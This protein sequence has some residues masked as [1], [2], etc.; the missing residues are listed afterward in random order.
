MS[1]KKVLI[2]GDSH[3]AFLSGENEKSVLLEDG[4]W[5]GSHQK[6]NFY[7]IWRYAKVCYNLNFTKLSVPLEKITPILDETWTVL[8]YFGE[9]DIRIHLG[10][11]K[12][13]E[14][15]VNSYIDQSI[16][17]FNQ[18]GVKV[19]FICPPPQ[20][21]VEYFEKATP[22]YLERFPRTGSSKERVEIYHEFVKFLKLGCLKNNLITPIEIAKNFTEGFSL[23]EHETCDGSHLSK[24]INDNILKYLECIF[25]ECPRKECSCFNSESCI[26][27]KCFP[28]NPINGDTWYDYYSNINYIY[29]EGN[30]ISSLNQKKIRC[31]SC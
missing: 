17:F 3:T 25:F 6:D 5:V 4:S 12:N 22:D 23:L 29:N 16:K 18:F 30:W 14:Q 27:L 10:K 1:N 9:V 15:T 7:F 13:V 19:G 26:I 28:K 31:C 2:V 24:E 8:L 20:C 21:D 11:N